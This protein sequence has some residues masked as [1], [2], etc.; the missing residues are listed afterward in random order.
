MREKQQL[1]SSEFPQ[2]DLKDEQCENVVKSI[3]NYVKSTASME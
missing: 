2:V 3:E 1:H